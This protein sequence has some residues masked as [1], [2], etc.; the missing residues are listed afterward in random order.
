MYFQLADPPHEQSV[1][2]E[3]DH[4]DDEIAPVKSI[5]TSVPVQQ[6]EICDL[7]CDHRCKYRSDQIQKICNIVHREQNRS[8]SSND[9]HHNS[10]VFSFDF[11]ENGFAGNP[12]RIRI[13]KRGSYGRKTMISRP[14]I[15]SPAFSKI[16]AMSDSPVNSAAPIPMTYIQQL[17]MP[18]TMALTAVAFTGFSAFS[19]IIADQW[20]P[21]KRHCH[22][23]F[24]RCSKGKTVVCGTLND[25]SVKKKLLCTKPMS[26]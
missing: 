4:P 25:I 18:Y 8:H 24:H 15:L 14:A 16:C 23:K 20:Q 11:T 2:N 21:G 7:N 9:R 22:S 17:T 6:E 3:T 13:Q 1:K 5:F 26:E 12:G 10:G 19:C